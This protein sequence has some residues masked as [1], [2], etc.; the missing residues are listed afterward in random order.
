MVIFFLSVLQII[1]SNRLSTTGIYIEKIENEVASYE[2]DNSLL[3]EKI[4][5]TSSFTTIASRA[6]E[7]GFTDKTADVLLSSPLPFAI[8]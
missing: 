5:N 7:M 4:Y 2:K 3:R 8:K 6:S 1:V